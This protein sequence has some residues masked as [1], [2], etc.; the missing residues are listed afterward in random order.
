MEKSED[1]NEEREWGWNLQRAKCPTGVVQLPPEET[2][3]R[4]NRRLKKRRRG[5]WK[6]PW[7]SYSSKLRVSSSSV[8]I[9]VSAPP[10]R[11]VSGKEM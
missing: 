8:G 9:L 4:A 11:A 6:E 7:T 1:S 3:T 10:P 5:G 2:E